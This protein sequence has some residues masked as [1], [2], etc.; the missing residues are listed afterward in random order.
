MV[1]YHPTG[2][3]QR[4]LIL[5]RRTD[6][7]PITREQILTGTL[8]PLSTYAGSKALAE[9]A[10]WKFVVEHPDINIT[11]RKYPV[12]ELDSENLWINPQS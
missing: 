2:T 4:R 1:R 3:F 5:S 7:N 10:V 12:F 9:R 8:D 11:V 6:W